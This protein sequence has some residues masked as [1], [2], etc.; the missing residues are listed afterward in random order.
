MDGL[1][2]M[3]ILKLLVLVFCLDLN[4]RYGLYS[5]YMLLVSAVT[6]LVIAQGS[7]FI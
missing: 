7:H 2:N 1:Q 6:V 5:S 4:V 3:T